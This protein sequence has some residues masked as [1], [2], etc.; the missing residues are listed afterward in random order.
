MIPDLGALG[1][2]SERAKHMNA[3][4][5]FE[6]IPDF[7]LVLGGPLYQLFRRA[8]LSGDATELV[9]RRILAALV[10]TWLPLLILSLV[11]GFALGTRSGSRSFT[12]SR[13]RCGS[14]SRFP[15]CSSPSRPYT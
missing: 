2:P 12:I 14:S 10:I 1:D 9:H 6:D 8:H 3:L 15:C 13:R 4:R 5:M 11:S 7:S